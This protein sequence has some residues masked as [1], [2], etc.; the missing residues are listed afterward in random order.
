MSKT[1]LLSALITN[2]R[3]CSV[4]QPIADLM[5][6]R[7]K[8]FPT[9]ISDN[10]YAV[11]QCLPADCRPQTMK[12]PIL[13]PSSLPVHIPL[14]F[15]YSPQVPVFGSS[16]SSAEFR[17]TMMFLNKNGFY[18]VRLLASRRTLLVGCLR[19]LIQYIRS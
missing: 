9:K 18:S 4:F 10:K 19:L 14:W 1:Y 7:E 5:F 8:M 12:F 17:D 13:E 6:T 2:M 11:L 16:K 3:Y 15:K